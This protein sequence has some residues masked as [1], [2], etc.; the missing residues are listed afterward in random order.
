MMKTPC[1]SPC[2]AAPEMVLG[3]KYDCRKV[4]IWA[5]GVTLYAMLAGRLP[6]EH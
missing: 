2:Y 1:G 5:M 4:D 3:K 6:F